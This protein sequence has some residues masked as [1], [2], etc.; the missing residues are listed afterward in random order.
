VPHPEQQ[1]ECPRRYQRGGDAGERDRAVGGYRIGGAGERYAAD[2]RGEPGFAHHPLTVRDE[3]Q[4]QRD[5]HRQQWGFHGHVRGEDILGQPG[6]LGQ[7]DDGQCH[8][9]EGHRCGVRHQ[10]HRGGLEWFEAEAQEH[11]RGDGDGVPKPA[12]ASIRAPKQK[13]MMMACTRWSP[14]TLAKDRRKTSKC[15]LRAVNRY[16]QLAFTTIHMEGNAPNA[17]PCAA[18]ATAVITGI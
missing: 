11:D 17:A 8:H 16:T 14:L 3:H 1:D 13:A 15:P 10:C 12:N 5:E 6:H 9:P 7:R 18:A 4:G 2:H